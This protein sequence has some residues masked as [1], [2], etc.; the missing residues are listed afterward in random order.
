M[1][2]CQEIDKVFNLFDKD[3]SGAIDSVELKDAMR[4]LGVFVTGADQMKKLMEKADKDGSGAIEHHEFLALMAELIHSRDSKLEVEK[5]F[6]MYDDDDNGTVELQNLRKSANELGYQETVS[7]MELLSMIKI[8]DK[9]NQN[10]V[11]KEDF[12]KMLEA[13][14]L[15]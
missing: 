1:E 5:A 15:F 6:R 3:G 7:D 12:M 14:G 10:A 9:K 11:D 8:A 4:A 13:A 2:E